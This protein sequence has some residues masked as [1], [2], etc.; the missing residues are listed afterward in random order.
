MENTTS[1]AS[2]NVYHQNSIKRIQN[3]FTSFDNRDGYMTTRFK[4]T[5]LKNHK[6]S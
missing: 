5:P 1:L 2:T 6:T 3:Q 4:E